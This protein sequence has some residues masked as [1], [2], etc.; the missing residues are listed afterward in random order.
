MTNETVNQL[1]P[2]AVLA[3]FALAV[4]IFIIVSVIV[5]H[6]WS[7]YGIP[8]EHLKRVRVIYFSVSAVLL[9]VAGVF[10]ITTF[11]LT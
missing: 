2:L 6:H 5:N 8:G 10:A 4:V 1:L 3:V 11:A 9:I 7:K